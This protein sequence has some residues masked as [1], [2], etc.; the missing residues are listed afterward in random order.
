MSGRGPGPLVCIPAAGR[1]T[2]MG[3]ADGALHKALAPLSNRAVLT[4]VLE[5]FPPDARFVI[6]LGHRADQLRAYLALAHPDRDI[7]LVA[8]DNYAGPA[9]GPGLSIL[10]CA[11]HLTE[12]FALAAADA[13]VHDLPALEGSSW[14]GVS[15]VEDPTAYLTLEVDAAHHV[16]RFQERTGPSQ[17]AYVG[18]A[19]IT[20]PAVYLD[21]LR[22]VVPSG[23]H[24][25][26]AGFQALVDA[27]VPI[28]ALPCD[29]TDTGTTETYAAARARFAET[30]SGGRA[31]TDVTYLLPGRVVK[32]FRDPDGARRRVLRAADLRAAIPP[33]IPAPP[34]WLAYEK[35]EGAVLRDRLGAGEVREVLDWI[36]DALWEE[37]AD[38]ASFRAA[39]RRFYGEKTLAR[40][41]AY[42]DDRGISE[43][44]SGTEVNGVPT[45]TVAEALERELEP[46]VAAAVPARFHGDLHEG[47][48]VAGPGGYRLID[49]RD[50]FGG[51]ADR[52]D[53]LYDLA[54]LV[55]T[56]ELPESVMQARAFQITHAADG[57]IGFGHPDSPLRAEGRRA[58]WDWC[59]ARELDLR[60]IGA[61]DA[62]VWINMA[63]L[64][65]RELGDYFYAFGRWLLE[66]RHRGD[67]SPQSEAALIPQLRGTPATGA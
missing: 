10:A 13:V 35:A 6:A 29:W 50:E 60:A 34:G 17:L 61:L 63:P 31:P 23:E 20:E 65:D 24:Q 54:K 11:E 3:F 44:P 16:R 47:N 59:A 39:A 41:G 27:R 25:A 53:Q 33:V 26:T 5:S 56:L 37:R 19:W 43:Q 9:S 28:R 7:T 51:L 12:P 57:A 45:A 21:G 52:G 55:H 8:V 40:L 15:H 38:G 62:L 22:A 4:H 32:W 64:Y 58:F 30:V 46:L 48:I 36:D 42:L 49:W 1:G 2:R 18:V 67:G 66:L 14:M